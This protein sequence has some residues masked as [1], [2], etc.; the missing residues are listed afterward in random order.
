MEENHSSANLIQLD[1]N[2]LEFDPLAQHV[3]KQPDQMAS[4]KISQDFTSYSDE[5][6]GLDS[7]S[8]DSGI[9]SGA[10]EQALEGQATSNTS[11]ALEVMKQSFNSDISQSNPL[12]PGNLASYG[13]NVKPPVT[14]SKSTG[15]PSAF[16]S[17]TQNKPNAK[18][19][20]FTSYVSNSKIVK[21]QQKSQSKFYGA[22]QES[23]TRKKSQ[24]LFHS[25]LQVNDQH[26][27]ST[28]SITR[29]AAV[30]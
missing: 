25:Y 27:G 30:E 14:H 19:G 3:P 12:L 18:S 15:M 6:L 22:S 26:G 1:E 4:K 13:N 24:S 5:L 17:H 20:T 9:A 8:K 10:S 11:N 7:S 21:A 2:L 28:T 16:S 23:K 29:F